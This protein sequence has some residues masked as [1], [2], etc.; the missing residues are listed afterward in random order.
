MYRHGLGTKKTERSS[1]GHMNDVID[2]ALS[3]FEAISST[4]MI[5]GDVV[6]VG[7]VITRII[8]GLLF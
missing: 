2:T 1:M 5:G 3:T 7:R 8:L 4:M 6:D